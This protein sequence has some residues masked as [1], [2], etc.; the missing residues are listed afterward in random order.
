MSG[1]STRGNREKRRV[2]GGGKA[3]VGHAPIVEN[4]GVNVGWGKQSR[5]VVGK[6]IVEGKCGTVGGCLERKISLVS[7]VIKREKKNPGGTFESW[8]K[9]KPREGGG[10]V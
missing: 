1:G 4:T 3:A 7:P 9:G 6:P 2:G 8:S 5:P 10:H